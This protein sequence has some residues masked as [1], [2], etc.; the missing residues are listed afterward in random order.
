MTEVCIKKRIHPTSKIAKSEMAL[1][2][3][4]P[5]IFRYCVNFRGWCLRLK[6]EKRVN[7]LLLC[8]RKNQNELFH[9]MKNFPLY[10]VD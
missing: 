6:L 7:H 1:S 9:T 5:C 4:R 8:L 3:S 2:S 10:V